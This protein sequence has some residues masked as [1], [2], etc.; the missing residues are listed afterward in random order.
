MINNEA[1]ENTLAP[2]ARTDKTHIGTCDM[3]EKQIDVL[4]IE[5][6]PGDTRLVME[7]LYDAKGATFCLTLANLL[8][9]G[10]ARLGEKRYDV[11]LLDLSLPDSCGNFD[12]FSRVMEAAPEIP[13]V[14]MSGFDDETVA[15]QTV[16]QGA[17]DYLLKGQVD[18]NLLVRAMRYAIERKKIESEKKLLI[19]ELQLALKKIKVLQG[20]LP[21]C[22]SCKR[23]RDD[24]GYWNQIEVYI[25]KH[26]NAD[27]THGICPD[28]VAKLYPDHV[29]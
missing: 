20:L 24:K 29:L 22:A 2:S 15:M 23:I 18:G 1:M 7:M 26:S 19:K 28:C 10:L 17:Q 14:V 8:S 5:D 12:T 11:V 27:F 6:N 21:I 4:L 13:I 3:T 16:R 25:S 9:I